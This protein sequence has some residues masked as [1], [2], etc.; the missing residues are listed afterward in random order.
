MYMKKRFLC[1][2]KKSNKSSEINAHKEATR[3]AA[4]RVERISA[5]KM[6]AKNGRETCKS[7]SV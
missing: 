7:L 5:E 1:I 2:R 4:E 3:S 6:Q